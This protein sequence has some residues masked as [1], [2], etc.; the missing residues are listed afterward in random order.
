[1]FVLAKKMAK[2]NHLG[3]L[4]AA[5]GVL[6]A[7]GLL[8]L[9]LMVVEARPAGAAFPG[10]NGK[11]AYAGF[12]GHDYEIYT[13]DARGGYR[14]KVT[15]NDT[16]DFN[17]SYSPGGK[18]IAYHVYG[19]RHPSEIYTINAWGGGRFLVTNNN[20]PDRNPSYSSSGKKIAFEGDDG[21]DSEIYT[22]N[23]WGEG[24]FLV[25]NNGT[26]DTEPMWGRRR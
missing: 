22:I 20:K 8:M 26:L 12:D 18:R 16:D 15:N 10:Q 24:R 19:G 3:A 5:V 6:V 11:I 13:I 9:M 4:T 14:V 7:E 1:L 17:P 23:A 25:T 21:H 2:T